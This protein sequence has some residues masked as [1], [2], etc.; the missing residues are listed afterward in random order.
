[1]GVLIELWSRQSLRVVGNGAYL[2]IWTTDREDASDSIVRGVSLYNHQSVR[3]PMGQDRS[4]GESLLEL[5]EGR[6]TGVT[7]AP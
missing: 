7:K 3:D 6:E 1:M 2:L 5:A 4:G